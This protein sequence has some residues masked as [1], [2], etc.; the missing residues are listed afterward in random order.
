MGLPISIAASGRLSGEHSEI[1]GWNHGPREPGQS[2]KNKRPMPSKEDR[3]KKRKAPMPKAL[4]RLVE[5]D[6]GEG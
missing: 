4:V 1:V 5:V 3:K 2:L 6:G